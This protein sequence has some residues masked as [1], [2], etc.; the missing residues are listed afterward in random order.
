MFRTDILA[1]PIV[2][3]PAQTIN[4][5]KCFVTMPG[6]IDATPEGCEHFD[7]ASDVP[8]DIVKFVPNPIS[9]QA[10]STNEIIDIGNSDILSSP[11]MTRTSG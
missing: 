2:P 3:D 7:D 10:A 4:N 6:V 9:I 11:N 5:S 8:E 1:L